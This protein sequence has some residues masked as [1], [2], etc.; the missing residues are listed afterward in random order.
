MNV[1]WGPRGRETQSIPLVVLEPTTR[2][3]SLLQNSHLR[4][5][6]KAPSISPTFLKIK[7][8]IPPLSSSRAP[9]RLRPT[10]STFRLHTAL[11]LAGDDA[12]S[13]PSPPPCEARSRWEKW[14]GARLENV[15]PHVT[16]PGPTG[17]RRLWGEKRVLA[18]SCGGRERERERT[19]EGDKE[20]PKKRDPSACGLAPREVPA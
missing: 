8:L 18:G 13:A 7:L 9:S 15:H 4:E 1:H 14:S 6:S 16:P 2:I 10:P 12:H 3:G 17:I 20:R 19:T 11:V 5:G